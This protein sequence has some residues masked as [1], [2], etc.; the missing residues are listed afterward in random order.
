M[1][2]EDRWL[3]AEGRHDRAYEVMGAHLDE[4]GAWFRVW[5]PNARAVS[6]LTDGN[7]W[8]PGA[9]ALVSS[10]EGIWE[11]HVAGVGAGTTYKYAVRTDHGTL[12]KIDPFAF[13]N[14]LPPDTA[15]MVWDLSHEWGDEEWVSDRGTHLAHDAP[16]SIYELHLGSWRPGYPVPFRDLADPLISH[17]QTHGFSHIELLPVME[18][19]FYGSWGYQLTGYFAPTARYGRP[20][21]FMFFVDSL[22][23]A[24]IGVILDWVPSHFPTDDHA[25]ALFDGTSLYEHPDPRRGFQPEW[26]SMVFN[27]GRNEVRSFLRSSAHFWVDHYHVDGFR[28]DAV[29][30]MLYLDYSRKPGE[31]APNE[32]GG[33]HHL[34][35]ISFL[36]D[37]N[38]SIQTTHPGVKMIAEEST[39]FSGVTRSPMDGG[40]GFA[41]KWDMGWMNDTLDHFSRE[42]V[43]R[44]H[45]QN[46]LTFRSMYA[47]S[48][49]FVLPLSHDE[50]VHGKGSLLGRM[51]GDDW[52]RYANLRLLLAYQWTLPG[53]KLLFMGGEL[54]QPTEWDHE[55]S[56]PWELLEDARHR[57]IS[58]LIADLNKLYRSEPA[59]HEKDHDPGAFEFRLDD[60]AEGVLAWLRWGEPPR[61]VLIAMG[62]TPGPRTRSVSVPSNGAWVELLS[63]DAVRYG[64]AGVGNPG[65]VIA[66]D[67]FLDVTIPPLGLVVLIPKE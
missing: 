35:A 32:H 49:A 7:G 13:H 4:D 52:Q 27:Y 40:L 22:H 50:V 17:L 33:N 30:S 67:G 31:W 23:Q 9:D 34:E 59:L 8:T 62:T 65:V 57:G 37:V 24:G 55:G 66:S 5:A 21:D 44:S 38:E 45:H 16:V 2:E 18:H 6:V 14:E 51:P 36:Q 15:S 12:T 11:G 56:L 60:P 26:G 46:E 29:A 10:N 1:T 47:G 39:A 61:P 43:H 19:P 28:V 63:T 64:G 20:Q 25:L 3:F 53:K 54:G 58:N 42:P 48:E 41:W